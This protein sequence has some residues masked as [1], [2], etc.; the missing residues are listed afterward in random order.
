MKSDT[1]T[2]AT[3]STLRN[4]HTALARAV[5]ETV[6]PRRLMA[7]LDES[8]SD[9]GITMYTTPGVVSV[10]T[11]SEVQ[12]GKVLSVSQ[13]FDPAEGQFLIRRFNADGTLDVSY[14]FNLGLGAE[15][16]R[17]TSIVSRPD[18][19]FY[20][21]GELGSSTRVG[22]VARVTAEGA[23]DPTFGGM[24]A[25]TTFGTIESDGI[26]FFQSGV[27]DVSTPHLAL[28]PDGVLN[29]GYNV[30]AAALSDLSQIAVLKL[31]N[32]GVAIGST[33]LFETPGVGGTLDNVLVRGTSLIL[34]GDTFRALAENSPVLG[35]DSGVFLGEVNAAG[36]LVTGAF[37]F[38]AVT[39]NEDA[40]DLAGAALTTPTGGII[41]GGN[42]TSASSG[43]SIAT[44]FLAFNS[45]FTPNASFGASG[46]SDINLGVDLRLNEFDELNN[47]IAVDAD[48]NIYGA[49][50]DF[51]AFEEADAAVLRLTPSGQLDPTF[52]TDGL[53][54]YAY[55]EQEFAS[56]ITLTAD[57]AALVAVNVV[58]IVVE[59]GNIVKYVSTLKFVSGVVAPPTNS[60]PTV[61]TVSGPSGSIET[62]Q[63]A[64]FT[65]TFSD[66]DLDDT[67]QVAWNFGDGF[68]LAYAVDDQPTASTSHVYTVAGNY[69]I[70]FTVKDEAGAT[71]TGTATITVVTPPP[72]V[73]Y[74]L[75]NGQ[76]A[77]TSTAGNDTVT[78]A[79]NATGQAVLTE[80]GV[81]YIITSAFSS[82][83]IN[84]A[85]GNDLIRVSTQFSVPTTLIGGDGND[86]LRGAN[87]TDVL[88]GDA[89]N[90]T[91]I[92]RNGRD[93]VVGGIGAD[94]LIGNEQDDILISGTT[95]YAS[96]DFVAFSA[97]QAE[98]TSNRA[99]I[100][101]VANLSGIIPP[102][103]LPRANGEYYLLPGTNVFNDT[104]IDTLVGGAGTDLPL[105]TLFGPN[106]DVVNDGQTSFGASVLALINGD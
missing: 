96:T 92:G 16:V 84:G 15:P 75:I 37:S 80:N 53:F 1:R 14:D 12:G 106:R 24:P 81:S 2:D 104:S 23:L 31:T 56:S 11:A 65:A 36:Q 4:R 28:S 59:S 17:T 82:I 91:L 58:D 83:V 86:T 27:S 33:L 88:L 77:L 35:D 19:S 48:G 61:A 73:P 38:T 21:A 42:V 76:L 64:A 32:E 8:F 79:K 51:V 98:W 13:Y 30:D 85:A 29:I 26:T 90:D 99:W 63:S 105:F 103:G 34:A 52:D 89:G 72:P 39:D 25:V 66:T 71:A 46:S 102:P 49:A 45:N 54:S 7:A 95:S 69:T 101:R 40:F 94:L 57:G 20:L 43:D 68:S 18:G 44:K 67:L 22:F 100:Y 60:P 55:A 97:I 5:V 50:L 78:V 74:T 10:A 62:G 41:V 6:E 47:A 3:P 70:T 87:G 93:I 9:D